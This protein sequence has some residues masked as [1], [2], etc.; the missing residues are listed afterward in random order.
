MLFN[1]LSDRYERACL[2]EYLHY[3]RIHTSE[4]VKPEWINKL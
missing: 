4:L 2:I 1:G 3:M